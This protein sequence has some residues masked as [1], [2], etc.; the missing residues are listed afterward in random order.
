QLA[1]EAPSHLI[2]PAIHKSKEEIAQLFHEKLGCNND[3]TPEYLT[4]VARGY[5]RDKYVKADIGITGANFIIRDKGSIVLLENEGNIRLSYSNPKVHIVLM[6]I[7]KM[8]RSFEDLSLFIP[9]IGVSANGQKTTGYMSIIN[10]PKKEDE[11]DGPEHV[12]FI[13]VDNGRRKMWQDEKL[14]KALYCIRCSA[15]YNV[16][17]VYRNIG[18]HAYGWVYQGPIGAV[19][20]PHF[21]GL[22]K[23]KDLPFATS[24][25]GACTDICPVKIPLHHLHLYNRDLINKK[26]FPFSFEK[27]VFI[28]FSVFMYIPGLYSF[29]SYMAKKFLKLFK[30]EPKVP[31]WSKSRAFPEF[32]RKSFKNMYKEMEK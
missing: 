32:A 15:C 16:C 29:S 12:Y 6:G 14:R 17:P 19:I 10:G 2:G 20:T 26:G 24:L 22:K 28:F 7:E 8:I 4:M 21:V 27:L 3:P 31:G 9:L 1:G 18:G 11:I 13:L 23:A 5:L 30:D 25:C